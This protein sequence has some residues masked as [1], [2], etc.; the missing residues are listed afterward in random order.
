[1]SIK[2]H[3]IVVLIWIV[4]VISDEHI[5]MCLLVICI[6]SL[7]N[8]IQVLSP[9]FVFETGFPYVAQAGLELTVLLP[10]SPKCWDYSCIPPYLAL[11]FKL[12]YLGFFKIGASRG[13]LFCFWDIGV[14]YIFWMLI[15]YQINDLPMFSPILWFA[16]LFC[17]LILPFDAQTFLILMKSNVRVFG[18][19]Y[20]WCHSRNH[21][22]IQY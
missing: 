7:T 22:Q 8:P 3:R 14:L 11:I 19:L 16:S 2:W 21:C 5:F 18:C 10:L 17:W 15:S 1:M 13:F 12:E 9:F 6:S 4:V 20:F